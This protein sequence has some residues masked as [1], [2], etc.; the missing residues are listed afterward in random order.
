MVAELSTSSHSA[1]QFLGGF[2]LYT[3]AV[4]GVLLAASHYLRSRPELL[5]RLQQRVASNQPAMFRRPAGLSGRQISSA[6]ARLE[7][8]ALLPLEP[9]KNVYVIRSEAERFL[10]ATGPEGTQLISRLANSPESSSHGDG[11]PTRQTVA[12]QEPRETTSPAHTS[13]PQFNNPNIAQA[14]GQFQQVQALAADWMLPV[15]RQFGP[16]LFKSLQPVSIPVANEAGVPPRRSASH[17]TN[18]LHP[19]RAFLPQPCVASLQPP[20]KG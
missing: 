19:V 15:L 9:G 14:L 17:A 4:I 6:S 3:G 10:I 18:A 13:R 12:T 8:E 16:K 2:V 5:R 1:W 11:E 7:V 20:R